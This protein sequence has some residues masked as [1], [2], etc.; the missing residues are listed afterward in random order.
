MDKGQIY[1]VLKRYINT[2]KADQKDAE[3][4]YDFTL[5]SESEYPKIAK[6]VGKLI[7]TDKDAA[8]YLK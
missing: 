5:I 3:R 7:E 2:R 4:R 8:Q 1:E 6:I